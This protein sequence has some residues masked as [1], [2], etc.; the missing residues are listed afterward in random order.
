MERRFSTKTKEVYITEAKIAFKNRNC[1][2]FNLPIEFR[3]FTKLIYKTDNP[4]Q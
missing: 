4:Y 1:I 3:F 2:D